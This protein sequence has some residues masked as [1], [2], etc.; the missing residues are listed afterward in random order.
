MTSDDNACHERHLMELAVAEM[1]KSTHDR[2][3]VGAVLVQDGTVIATGYRTGNTHAKRVAIESAQNEGRNPKGATLYTTLEPCVS[4]ARESCASLIK[5]VGIQTVV[6]GSFDPNPE[7]NRKGWRQLRNAGIRLRDFSPD[8]RKKID[9]SHTTFTDHFELGY[10]PKGGGKFDYIV[11][12]G[13]FEFRY[14]DADV[15]SI[16]TRWA[17]VG[18]GKIQALALSPANGAVPRYAEAFDEVDDPTAYEF[19]NH[20]HTV[21]VRGIVIFTSAGWAV[22]VRVKD[23]QNGDRAVGW[24]EP[25]TDSTSVSIE[26]QVR[27]VFGS[28]NSPAP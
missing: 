15:R 8:L 12:H 18:P 3:K 4:D 23:V 11:N 25:Q 27:D 1:V 7:I 5:R 20:W 9:A 26:W 19:S 24:G 13:H 22:L 21:P 14:S 10:G 16:K 28:P 2:L 6:I 17:R